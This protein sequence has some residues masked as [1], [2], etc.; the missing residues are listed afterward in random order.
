MN[1]YRLTALLLLATATATSACSS[2]DDDPPGSGDIPE[3]SAFKDLSEAPPAIRTAAQAVVRI[4][5]TES[6]ATGS[7]ISGDGLLLTNNHVLGVDV[8]PK[9]GCYV[10]ITRMY[11][12]YEAVRSAE[13]IFVEPQHIDPGLDMAVLQ[14]YKV[15]TDGKRTQERLATPQFLTIEARDSASLL[16]THVNVVGHP[17]GK[18][19]KWTSG[20][21]AQTYGTWFKSTAFILP[22]NSG[23]PLLDDNGKIVGLLHRGPTAQDLVTR[24]GINVYSIGTASA[25]V[26]AAM[27]APLPPATRSLTQ[28]ATE[29]DIA[30][31]QS[32]YLNAH[33]STA[34]VKQDPPANPTTDPPP[35]PTRD[36]VTILGAACDKGLA[37]ADFDSPEDL[38]SALA[39]CTDAINWIVC[40]ASAK[41]DGYHLC[42]SDE[43]KAAWRTRFQSAFDKYRAFNGQLPLEMITY[44]PASLERSGNESQAVA[45]GKLQQM[46]SDVRPPLD[47]SLSIYLAVFG[48]TDYGGTSIANFVRN[49]TKTVHYELSLNG[50]AAT[51][52]WLNN[53][54]QM[55]ADE[56]KKLLAQLAADDRASL[57]QK[58]YIE[59]IRYAAGI[60][61]TP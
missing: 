47:F 29:A 52:L 61:D 27:N 37:R 10:K 54:G 35:N 53:D 38:A 24:K 22:G 9:E 43:A 56:T 3:F 25:A 58:L 42:P 41:S 2:S 19:K 44:A 33:V 46:L 39:P 20:D 17:E 14:A 21:V 28:P 8:C 31:H 5:T 55:K 57:G 26:V 50:I 48:V 45:R 49:Y 18:L 59:D 32:V 23:S 6:Y 36:L 1:A 12:R 40:D 16:G 7:F 60:L 51:A 13:E 15:G 11:Q 34:T 4:R 30:E